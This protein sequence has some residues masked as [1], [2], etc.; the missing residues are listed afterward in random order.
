[1]GVVLELLTLL[2]FPVSPMCFPVPI[3]S[4]PG[5]PPGCPSTEAPC[6]TNHLSGFVPLTT[7]YNGA[8]HKPCLVFPFPLGDFVLF[9]ETGS[10][11][12]QAGLELQIFLSL[13]SHSA[14]IA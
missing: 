2:S 9:V 3:P 13:P 5:C 7:G 8:S 4:P 11:V 12:A 10:Y 6:E 14:G 1:M